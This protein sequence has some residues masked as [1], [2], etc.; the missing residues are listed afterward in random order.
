MQNQHL[1]L[2]G[3][4]AIYTRVASPMKQT[5]NPAKSEQ[6]LALAKQ[7]GFAEQQLIIFA[8]DHGKSDSS[9][10]AKRE[11]LIA[12]VAAI[13][14]GRV[15][16]VLVADKNRLFRDA[17][18]IQVDTFIRLCVERNVLVITPQTTYDFTNPAHVSLFRFH[19]EHGYSLVENI[20]ADK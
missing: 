11:R 14:Q 20:F 6:L 18:A 8:Q 12:M 17:E 5:Q 2:T 13:E 19:C 9:N 15:Q 1:P 7:L 3:K 10:K 4:V 16:A